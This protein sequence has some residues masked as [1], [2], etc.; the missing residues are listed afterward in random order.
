MGADDFFR[1]RLDEMVGM[2]HSLVTLARLMPSPQI[3]VALAP[4]LAHRG[5]NV[6]LVE[7]ADMFGPLLRWPAP[8]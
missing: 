6:R 7:G 1:A 4:A 2:R 8:A 3:E 5:R